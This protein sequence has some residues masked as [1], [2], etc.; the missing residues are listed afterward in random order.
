MLLEDRV[1]L[2][3]GASSGIGRAIAL[4]FADEGADVV[5]D[6]LTHPNDADAVVRD[7]QAKGRRGLAVKADVSEVADIRRMVDQA[8]AHFGRVDICVNNA[9]VQREAAFLDVTEEDWGFMTGVDL[10]GA[11]FVA[12]ACARDMVKR[13]RGRILNITSVHQM[14]AKPRFAPY[15]AAK[16]GVGMLTK[17][18][19]MELAEHH[20]NVNAIAPGAIETPMN[21]DVLGDPAALAS[22]C[23]EIPWGR[24]GT[25][26]E[27]AGLAAW[28][29]SDQADYVTGATFVIDGGLMQQVVQ[30]HEPGG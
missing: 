7:V 19:A 16:G 5:V 10:K 24:F 15:C 13:G 27:V 3:T 11:F 28:L 29:A 25:P 17:T 8:V 12:Q 1:A 9:G 23:K 18:L 20:V 30:Y 26:E 21:A 4:R 14:I 6:Y 2:V 22:V